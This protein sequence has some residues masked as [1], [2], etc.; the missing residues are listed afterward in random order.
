LSLTSEK[1]RLNKWRELAKMKKRDKPKLDSR[2]FDELVLEAI[3]EA[4]LTLG[5]SITTS[6]Y[7]H[8]EQK[9]TIKR[10]EIP[11][12]LEDFSGVLERIFGLGAQY[13][14]VLIMKNLHRKVGGCY[15]WDSPSVLATDLT[16]CKY[17]T[18]MKLSYEDP[19]KIGEFEVLIDAEEKQEQCT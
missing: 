7:Y 4:L 17:V 3:D 11:H 14:E 13:L 5:Q 18:L 16:F 9:F 2:S 6:I 10:A 8:L 1:L 15:N 19:G 12:R